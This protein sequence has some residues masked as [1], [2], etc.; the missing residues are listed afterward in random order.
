[1]PDNQSKNTKK[2]LDDQT[3]EPASAS[4]KNA[5]KIVV[6]VIGVFVVL[7]I[8]GTIAFGVFGAKIAENAIESATNSE[9]ETSSDG[10][11]NIKSNNNNSETSIQAGDNAELPDDLPEAV[12]VYEPHTVNTASSY[13]SED[14]KV[15]NISFSSD[16]PPEEINDFYESELETNGWEIKSTT[17]A[18]GTLMLSAINEDA[19]VSLRFSA[20]DATGETNF[21]LYVSN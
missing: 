4:Q 14:T 17:N 11:V 20:Q 13:S 7:G 9:I 15:W 16:S 12:P 19:G 6:I 21:N 5:L 8:L 3:P 18:S 1:M 2:S 10:S